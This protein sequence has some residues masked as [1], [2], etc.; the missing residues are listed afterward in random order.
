MVGYF[1]E[2]CKKSDT[3]KM[4]MKEDKRV[5]ILEHLQV[6][7]STRMPIRLV[8]KALSNLLNPN[9]I[10]SFNTLNLKLNKGNLLPTN[11]LG[12]IP[13]YLSQESLIHLL[14]IC[15]IK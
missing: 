9:L 1:Y 3:G 10:N 14:K 13:K 12:P 2:Y 5:E 7:T 6:G 8:V 11:N 15:Q 4:L